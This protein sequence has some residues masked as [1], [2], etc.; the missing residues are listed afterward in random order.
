MK[1]AASSKTPQA[2]FVDLV[3][4]MPTRV[5]GKFTKALIDTASNHSMITR[6]FLQR[7]GLCYHK[8]AYTTTGISSSAAPCLG[9]VVLDTRVGRRLVAVKYTVVESLPAAAIDMHEPNEVL[10]ALDVTSAVNMNIEFKHPRIVVTV[11]PEKSARR[12]NGRTWYHIINHSNHKYTTETSALDDFIAKPAELK[13]LVNKASQ[14]KAPLYVVKIKPSVESMCSS[15]VSS[16]KR[17]YLSQQQAPAP[18]KQDT[19]NIPGCI[20]EVIQKHKTPGGTLGPAPPNTTAQGFEM[21]IETL[22]GAR[23]RAARQYRLTPH[24]QSELEQQV[25]HLLDMGWIQPSISPWASSILFAPKPGGKLRLCVG[26]RYLNENTVKNTYPL[27]RIDT[28]LDKLKGHRYFSA[29]DLASGYHQIKLSETAQPKT[30]FRT[31]DGLYQWTVMPFGLTNAPSVFQ[32]AMHVVL[33]GLIGKICLAYLDDIIVLART[34]EEHA[35]NLD[36]VLSRLHEHQDFCN[37]EKCQFAM[38]EIKYLGHVVTADTVKPDPHKVEV[39]RAWPSADIQQSTNNIRS[40]LG[41]AGY[42]RRFIPKFPTLAAPLLER[43]S[44]KE[45]LPWTVQCEQSFNDIKNALINA[46]ALH[47]PDLSKPFHVYSDASDYAFGAVLTQKHE[48]ELKPVAWA[49]RKMSKAEVNYYTLEKEL[50]AIIFASRQW[51]CYLEN[52]QPVYIHSDHNPLRFLQTQ[53]KLTGK[54]ARWVE[55]LS[56]INWYITYIPGDKNVVADAVSRATHLPLSQVVL[57]DGHTLAA[58]KPQEPYSALSLTTALVRRDPTQFYET[59]SSGYP[60]LVDGSGATSSGNTSAPNTARQISPEELFSAPTSENYRFTST[61]PTDLQSYPVLQPPQQRQHPL[62][63]LQAATTARPPTRTTRNSQRRTIMSTVH[64]PEVTPPRLTRP[65]PSALPPPPPTAGNSGRILTPGLENGTLPSEETD[66]MIADQPVS[67]YIDPEAL[68]EVGTGLSTQAQQH[69]NLD[70]K[71]DEFWERLR[72]GYAHDPAFMSP[73]TKYR[74]DKHLQ[75]YFLDHRLVVPDH[76]HLRKQILLWHHEHPW[77]AHL[78]IKRTHALITD[79]FYWPKISQ[80]IKDFVAQC[81]SCQTMKSPGITTAALSPLP[82]PSACWRIISLDA[83]TQL[84][85]TTSNMDCIIVFVD[86]FSKMV[87]LIPTVSTLD[88]PGFAKLFFQHIYPHYGLPLGICSDRGVQWNNAFFR[89]VCSHMGIQLHLTFSYH[90]QANG[91]VERMNRV[92]E[93]AL[94]HF[95]GPAHDDWDEYIPHIEFSI[96]NSRSE[97]TGC[98]PFQLNRITPPL[99]PTALA[100]NLPTA[101]RPAPGILHRMYFHLAK[102]ALSLSKQSMWSNSVHPDFKEKFKVGSQVLLSISKISLHHPSL[103]RKF[104]A[105]WIGPCR[106]TE[107]VGRTAARIQLPSTL[108]KLR[109]H[110]VF[111]FSALKPYESAYYNDSTAEPQERQA[112]DL[113]D[114][115][116]VESIL[117]YKR[118]HASSQDPLDKG[119]HYL[120]HWRGYSSKHDMWLPVRALSNCLDKVADYLFQNASTRQRDVMIDQFARQERLQLSHLLARAQRTA[121]RPSNNVMSK[122]PRVTIRQRPRSKRKTGSTQQMAA[123]STITPCTHCGGPVHEQH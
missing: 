69:L 106:V 64:T 101:Q 28:L 33:K 15:A 9:S 38:Q 120:V 1:C 99:S 84:P 17:G 94:R 74:F 93:E 100:F 78:G 12:R 59:T 56:R 39:L 118:A 103:R 46:T 6:S 35:A 13:S 76:D 114:V 113:N 36:V 90:P 70:V 21:N 121:I 79:A 73:C 4:T 61:S 14:G 62:P 41:L 27:P 3:C 88:G 123:L 117:D 67:H 25:Q 95:V 57:H 112:S 107:L 65:S 18:Q 68:K 110:D 42:F 119:P 72:A 40:F 7:H 109:L 24:E 60:T 44:S 85:K 34:P 48:D 37:V 31:P 89:S 81:H 8:Q 54:Q 83:I 105:R 2:Q 10:F 77:H 108:Q 19:T 116:E 71:I 30:A 49:G 104:T 50:A 92:I 86:Q 22:P 11:P 63:Y 52:N 47:H 26:Y 5:H 98:T 91:Q 53:K 102:Q 20:Q 66:G 122:P 23:P 51:R 75:V 58:E 87:R 16:R 45:K 97:S 80:D 29:L 111:H 115:F 96:N 43:V 32:Q 55:S 82:V